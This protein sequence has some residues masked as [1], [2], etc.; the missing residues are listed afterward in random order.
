[1]GMKRMT[2]TQEK[3]L[4]AV[5][6]LIARGLGS[7]Q[8]VISESVNRHSFRRQQIYGVASALGRR[9]IVLEIVCSEE[10][11]KERIL[12]RP[13]KDGLVS[14]PN[15]PAVYNKSKS[16]WED[17]EIDFKFPGED[18][19]AYLQFDS[20]KNKLRR[21]ITRRGIGVFLS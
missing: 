7:G 18:H 2:K 15:D 4:R 1:M 10:T 13:R 21:I 20:E 17:V 14:D 6:C 8:G 16:F 3:V 9:V 19:V 5:D 12:S 11:A